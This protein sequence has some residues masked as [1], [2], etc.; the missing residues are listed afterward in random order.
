MQDMPLVSI[1]V[2]VYNVERYLPQCLD[3]LINQTYSNLEI[4]CVN[5]GSAD[6]SLEILQKYK[7]TDS[8]I[9]IIDKQNAGVSQARND[10]LFVISGKY[11]MFVDADDWIDD[12]TCENA[13]REAESGGF[14]VVMWSYISEYASH[15]EKKEIFPKTT[16]FELDDISIKLHR[17]FV[18]IV[19]EELS[20]PEL[21]D[22]LC[23]VWCKLYKV[24]LIRKVKNLHFVDL[25][26]IGTYEDGFF[27]LEIF[28]YV[29]RACYLDSYYY[30]YRRANISSETKKYRPN[31]PNQWNHLFD[32]MQEYINSNHL[33]DIY[34]VALNNRVVLSILGL[35]LN[36]LSSDFSA[37]KKRYLI[38]E[39]ISSPRYQSACKTLT[40]KFFPIH[41]KLFYFCAKHRLS[42]GLYCLLKIIKKIIS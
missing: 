30:H 33:S 4:I 42:F 26:E 10:A 41:W 31:L 25:S 28:K 7:K 19:N 34:K 27:N 29:N 9:S 36:I 22:S 24:E 5:D 40:F 39:I 14:D 17:R 32:L 35:G 23:P 11:L 3:S 1:I 12:S 15:S 2:P 13:V 20:H 18:G 37:P 38:K 16:I 8:R 21:A 6:N